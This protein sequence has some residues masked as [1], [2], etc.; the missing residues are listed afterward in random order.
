MALLRTAMSMIS[1]GVIT[2]NLLQG[3]EAAG[4]HLSHAGCLRTMGMF[5][6][7]MLMSAIGLFLFVAI[8]ARAL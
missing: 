3:F 6:T 2:Y 8:I 7:G 4:T 1:F 5:L